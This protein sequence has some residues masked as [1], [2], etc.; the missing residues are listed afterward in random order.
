M[1]STENFTEL[2]MSLARRLNAGDADGATALYAED[3]AVL[4]PG[5]PVSRGHAEIRDA[6]QGAIDAGLEVVEITCKECKIWGGD[7]IDRG[8]LTARMGEAE[9]TGKYMIWWKSDGEGWKIH[10]DIWNFND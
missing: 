4:P 8:V 3:G 7:A 10:R 6:W 2:N 1:T 5:A 9:M